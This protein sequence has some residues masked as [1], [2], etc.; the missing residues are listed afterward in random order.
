VPKLVL[1]IICRAASAAI[2]L[3]AVA[4]S[5]TSTPQGEAPRDSATVPP[6]AATDGSMISNRRVE[7]T[8]GMPEAHAS[9][10]YPAPAPV[11]PR[12]LLSAYQIA[13]RSIILHR[14]L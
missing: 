6:G 13:D 5:S 4:C 9:G 11:E 2:V 14:R 1:G 8:D 10:P 7:A 3:I 12:L